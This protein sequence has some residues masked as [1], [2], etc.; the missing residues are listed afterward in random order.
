MYNDYLNIKF[1]LLFLNIKKVKLFVFRD[2]KN[3]FVWNE[4]LFYYYFDMREE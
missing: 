4:N 3:Y 1:D 2:V